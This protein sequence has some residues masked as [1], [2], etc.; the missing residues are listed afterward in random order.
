V[1]KLA[2]KVAVMDNILTQAAVDLLANTDGDL[3]NFSQILIFITKSRPGL[4]YRNI[5]M[6]R[7][8]KISPE[9]LNRMLLQY[10]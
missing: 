7:R 1:D 9:D 10:S 2:L 5:L 8:S 4:I 6:Q 3:K